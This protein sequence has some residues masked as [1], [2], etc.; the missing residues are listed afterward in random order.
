MILRPYKEPAQDLLLV[1]NRSTRSSQAPMLRRCFGMSKANII[2]ELPVANSKVALLIMIWP[3]GVG[4]S[5]GNDYWYVSTKK[6]GRDLP[7]C[8]A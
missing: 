5:S 8:W 2:S 7:I 4:G 1:D 6:E 3:M